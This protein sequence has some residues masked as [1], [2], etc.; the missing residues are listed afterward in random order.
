MLPGR[1]G[2]GPQ[3]SD[4]SRYTT[5]DRTKYSVGRLGVKAVHQKGRGSL[6]LMALRAAE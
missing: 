2:N 5:L 6:G 4:V 3:E 1:P